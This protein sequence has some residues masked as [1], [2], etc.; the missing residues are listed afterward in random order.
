MDNLDISG[1]NIFLHPELADEEGLLAA[2]ADLSVQTLLLAYS[3]GI[4]PWYSDGSPILW[5]SPDPRMVLF[6]DEFKVSKSLLQTIRNK[7]ME[8][9]FDT[10]FQSVIE[11][12]S[13]VKRKAQRGTWITKEMKQAYIALHNEGYAHSVETYKNNLLVGG[14]YG[15]SLGGAFFGESMFHLITD[16]SKVALYHLAEKARQFQFDFIDVQQS[17]AHLKSLGARDLPRK[18]FIERLKNAL[19]KE[20]FKG[21]WNT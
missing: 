19:K 8:V 15:V 16:A 14:L 17:T 11:H 18:E 9:R 2:G 5:W 3:N 4:F 20:T 6:P 1:Y 12:C 21:S 7:G 13:R 10:D